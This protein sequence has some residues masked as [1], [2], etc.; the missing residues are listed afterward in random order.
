MIKKQLAL[1]KSIKNERRYIKERTALI[2]K[3][4]SAGELSAEQVNQ[5]EFEKGVLRGLYGL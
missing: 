5:F 4:T 2:E 3:Y 1:K